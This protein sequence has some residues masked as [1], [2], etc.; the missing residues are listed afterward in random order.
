M[1]ETELA[2]KKK[3]GFFMDEE[4]GEELFK[5][6]QSVEEKVTTE[7]ASSRKRFQTIEES[8]TKLLSDVDRLDKDTKDALKDL[9]S[10]KRYTNTVAEL[11]AKI[12]RMELQLKREIKMANWDPM[13]NYLAD[14]ETRSFGMPWCAPLPSV[15]IS[16]RSSPIIRRPRRVSSFRP[17]VPDR[18]SCAPTSGLT[19]GTC[20]QATARHGP[21]SSNARPQPDNDRSNRHGAAGC[22]VRRGEWPTLGGHA[23]G[24]HHGVFGEPLHLFALILDAG[25]AG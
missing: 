7:Q 4:A 21:P 1:D 2:E 9:E 8:N 19:Y 14:Q 22:V 17:A 15:R 10:V 11:Q 24:Q 18:T 13:Q 16:R 5:T 12:M 25:N 20:W 23:E 3:R 6:L